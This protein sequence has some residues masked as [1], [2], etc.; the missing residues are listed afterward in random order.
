M[1]PVRTGMGPKFLGLRAVSCI[2]DLAWAYARLLHKKALAL[3]ELSIS[4][5]LEGFAK[6]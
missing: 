6:I 1:L 3:L 2:L 5:K 4:H